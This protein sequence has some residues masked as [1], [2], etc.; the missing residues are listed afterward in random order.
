MGP[1][2]HCYGY[3][4]SLL[5]SY[6]REFLHWVPVALQLAFVARVEV[7]RVVSLVACARLVLGGRW[8]LRV[9]QRGSYKEVKRQ[10]LS[11]FVEWLVKT[12]EG[13]IVLR[14]N[15]IHLVCFGSP[16]HSTLDFCHL[17]AS[18]RN[19]SS[20]LFATSPF[21][22]ALRTKG[23]FREPLDG[24][25]FKHA[26]FA[27]RGSCFSFDASPKIIP[28]APFSPFSCATKRFAQ[29]HLTF[30][31]PHGLIAMEDHS[32]KV[33][34]FFV[35]TRGD[36]LPGVPICKALEERGH[37]A[38]PL[39]TCGRDFFNLRVEWSQRAGERRF[40]A[41]KTVKPLRS[42]FSSS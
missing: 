5:F 26:G 19:N 8:P 32:L 14:S 35:G 33:L 28:H 29:L 6:L 37:Q 22:N 27:L 18:P 3:G 7:R 38:R 1:R 10:V 4:Q 41:N 9:E 40:R 23:L 17:L 21:P 31:E 11:S 13:K 2:C 15:C 20:L 36:V 30:R 25:P 12:K 39:S 42:A 34:V 16:S 24:L